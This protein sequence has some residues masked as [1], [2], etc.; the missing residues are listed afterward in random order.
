MKRRTDLST[1]GDMIDTLNKDLPVAMEADALQEWASAMRALA[2]Y[3]GERLKEI[4]YD[5][6]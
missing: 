3:Q 5:D 6:E 2:E 4:H 1:I